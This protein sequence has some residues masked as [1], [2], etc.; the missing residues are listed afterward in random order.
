MNTNAIILLALTIFCLSQNAVAQ[1]LSQRRPVK[2]E[3]SAGM[4]LLP[5]FFKDHGSM[6][7]PPVALTATYRVAPSFGLGLFG[8]YAVSDTRRKVFGDGN[9]TQFRHSLL[10]TGIRASVHTRHT[11]KWEAYGGVALGL[12]FSH[13]DIL[14]GDADY[15][16]LHRNFKENTT[17]FAYTGF[18]GGRY[19]LT[20]GIGVFGELGLGVSLLTAGVQLR[21]Y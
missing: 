11:E 12:Q 3:I 14:E 9:M 20:P 21:W 17:R 18:V 7:T 10:H 2:Y 5:T 8:G 6:V 4:G 19:R 13:F 15:L 1:T 16:K